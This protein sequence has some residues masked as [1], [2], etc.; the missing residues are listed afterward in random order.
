MCPCYHLSSFRMQQF[1]FGQSSA[2]F[3]FAMA[4][5]ESVRRQPVF[6]T[7][8]ESEQKL[9]ESLIKKR[10]ELAILREQYDN[11]KTSFA[12]LNLL[13]ATTM[14]GVSQEEFNSTKDKL[15]AIRLELADKQMET[16]YLESMVRSSTAPLNIMH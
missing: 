6:L 15:S 7:A 13:I 11:L 16:D 10:V 9:N 1:P 4:N 3:P 14:C 2:M 5:V 12:N 8:V